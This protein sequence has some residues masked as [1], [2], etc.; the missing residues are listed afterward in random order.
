MTFPNWFAHYADKFFERNLTALAGQPGLRFLQVGAFTGDASLWLLDN[1][2]TGDGSVLIDV[3]TWEGSNEPEHLH[4][5]FAKVERTYDLHTAKHRASGRLVKYKGTS[6]SYF[7]QAGGPF[8]FVYID[9][10]HT[11]FGV[12]ADAMH[13][14]Q[15]VRPGGLIA[16]DDYLW[17]S[18]FGAMFD[19]GPAI[20]VVCADDRLTMLE[21]GLQVWFRVN[22]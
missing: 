5:D 21:S 8:D 20:D 11:A 9:G 22:V 13:A 17:K 7:T 3:D 1:I 12:L 2:L 18:G 16:F 15:R 6:A 19:P 4:M 10:D 14:I